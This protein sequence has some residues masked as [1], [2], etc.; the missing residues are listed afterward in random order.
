MFAALKRFLFAIVP[1]V[2][3][4]VALGALYSWW[5]QRNDAAMAEHTVY[6]VLPEGQDPA[7][8]AVSI[9]LDAAKEEGIPMRTISDSDFLL[10]PETSDR[11]S[12]A[13]LP[14]NLHRQITPVVVNRLEQFAARG[15]Q[16]M[17]VYDGGTVISSDV[18]AG[19]ASPLSGLVG[20]R[21]GPDRER[22]GAGGV[23]RGP[24]FVTDAGVRRL[25]LPPGKTMEMPSPPAEE[26][27]HGKTYAITG[28]QY[29][30]LLYPILPTSGAYTGEALLASDSGGV[31]AGYRRL[32]EGGVLFVNT[33]IGY[34]KGQTDGTLLHAFLHHLVFDRLGLPVLKA[35]ADGIGG[36]VFNWHVDSNAS[37]PEFERL[38]SFGALDQGPFSIHFT[39]GPDMAAF[40]DKQ[41]LDL[42][43]NAQ[44]RKWVARF[45]DRGDALGDHGGW[46]HNY[47]GGRVNDT[48]RDEM[49]KYLEMNEKAVSAIA[50]RPSR[51]YS[52]PLGNQPE[53]VT[54]WLEAH[55][56]VAYYFTGNTGMAPTRSYRNGRLNAKH[57]WSFP[58]L[59][60][61]NMAAF[62]EFDEEELSE[63]TVKNWLTS[64]AD[65]TADTG[66]LRTIYSHPHGFHR[67]PEA[68][69]ALFAHTR[70]LHA[71]GR[72]RWTTMSA[73]ADFLNRREQAV[74]SYVGSGDRLTL[75]ATHP[76]DLVDLA[77]EV[78]K[79]GGQQ[80]RVTVGDGRVEDVGRAWR[81]VAGHGRNFEFEFTR[82]ALP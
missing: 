77:W 2:L 7:A 51:E 58:V 55:N 42:E 61:G 23:E 5:G 67:Y 28:Y 74:W 48:N 65:F 79:A 82:K 15:G 30:A 73:A 27:L 22:F 66:T 12:A 21:Y 62:E 68:L 32:G 13:I 80:P 24:L 60:L 41:G 71:A 46:I 64:A 57:I 75:K 72:F 4:F 26:L 14:D 38:E 40:G 10:R 18:P 3:L 47:F 43:H 34:L 9:W 17:V 31:A 6:L 1:W 39:A 11:G 52:A 35:T 44:A 16:L 20:V 45:R 56:M 8:P 36:L 76:T 49:V 63:D 78:P 33:P 69:R 53:W 54:E 81:V 29:G 59:I 25:L 19:A 70:E 37:T 50:G